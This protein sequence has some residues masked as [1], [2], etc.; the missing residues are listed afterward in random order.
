MKRYAA[1]GLVLLFG[2]RSVPPPPPPEAAPVAQRSVDAAPRETSSRANVRD[3]QLVPASAVEDQLRQPESVA[4]AMDSQPVSRRQDGLRIFGAQPLLRLEDAIVVALGRNPN[5]ETVRAA[6][7][8]ARA[9]YGV[10]EVYPYNPQFQTQ[11]LP[12]TRD[13]NG[14]DAPVSQ[15]HAIVET[16]ELKPQQPFREQSAGAALNQVRWNIQQAELQTIAQSERLYFAA[17]YQRDLRDAAFALVQL[18][19]QLVAVLRRRYTAGQAVQS[20][21]ALADVETASAERQAE[22]A[23]AN[24]QT[25]LFSLRTFLALDPEAPLE[26]EPDWSTWRWRCAGDAL[27]RP[28]CRSDGQMEAGAPPLDAMTVRQLAANRP[29]VMAARAAA[30]AAQANLRLACAARVPNL[31]VGPLY[32]RDDAATEFWGVQGQIDLPVVNS[33]KPLVRQRELELRQQ[34]ITAEQ[35]ESQAV[36]EATAAIARYER[37]R[38]L[39]E[40]SRLDAAAPIADA[41]RPFEDQFEAGQIDLLS[42]LAVRTSVIQSR[43]SILDLLNELA[44]A[45]ADVTLTTGLLPDELIIR[46][47]IPEAPPKP[48]ALPPP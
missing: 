37:A 9:A 45:G 30:D 24:Y 42:V 29:D 11:V 2:C 31:Q 12:Y 15:Q 39:W 5:L 13:R 10:A 28:A 34:A 44:Q 19:R 43:R 7:P 8:A 16:F 46:C 23:E 35:L 4:A 18:N 32:E 27:C 40:R 22:L 21:V 33:G 25:A 3:D 1:T 36:N 48:E 26:L 17:L 41:L 47:V 38:M 6:E 14:N 20:E